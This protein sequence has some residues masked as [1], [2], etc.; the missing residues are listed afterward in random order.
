MNPMYI[1]L[2]LVIRYP[3]YQNNFNQNEI[4][5]MYICMYVSMYV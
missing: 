3:L 5:G 4:P 2:I 1:S